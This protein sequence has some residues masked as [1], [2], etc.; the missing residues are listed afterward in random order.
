MNMW[1]VTLGFGITLVL[2]GLIGYF[3][4]ETTSPTALIPAAFGFVLIALGIMARNERLRKHAMHGAAVIGLLGFLGSASGIVQTLAMLRGEAID[5][6]EAAVARTVM[7][8]LCLA[9]VVLT[10]KSFIDA[11]RAR[12]T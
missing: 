6:P 10:V 1:Q 12:K 3:G 7:A 4:T 11:R 8:L 9:F 2:V 5:R